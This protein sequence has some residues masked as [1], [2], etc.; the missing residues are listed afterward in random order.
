MRFRSGEQSRWAEREIDFLPSLL[1]ALAFLRQPS[2]SKCYTCVTSKYYGLLPLY[3]FRSSSLLSP[4]L[5]ERPIKQVPLAGGPG[6][7]M[8]PTH[9]SHQHQPK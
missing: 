5:Y 6:A 8:A 9:P 4:S 2:P 7:M 3:P 1:T